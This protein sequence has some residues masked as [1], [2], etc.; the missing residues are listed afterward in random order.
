MPQRSKPTLFEIYAHFKN[1][2]MKIIPNCELK[3][4]N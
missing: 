1:A 2:H 3:I 4:M